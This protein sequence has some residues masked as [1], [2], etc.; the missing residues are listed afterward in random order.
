MQLPSGFVERLWLVRGIFFFLWGIVLG[1]E[2]AL[3]G[4]SFT[5]LY[6]HI[7]IGWKD[8]EKLEFLETRM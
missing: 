3:R 5:L 4:C 8:K 1:E 6:R 2:G 7:D